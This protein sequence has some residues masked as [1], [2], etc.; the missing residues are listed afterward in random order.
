MNTNPDRDKTQPYT[1]HVYPLQP[2]MHWMCVWGVP[3]RHFTLYFTPRVE[4]ICIVCFFVYSRCILEY[5]NVF[6]VLKVK[7]RKTSV[8]KREKKTGAQATVPDFWKKMI[9]I[10]NWIIKIRRI[11]IQLIIKHKK[12]CEIIQNHKKKTTYIKKT[13]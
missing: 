11:Q 4:Y 12:S 3:Q 8:K 13:K 10:T 7:T 2:S 6:W 5:F 1:S 9:R